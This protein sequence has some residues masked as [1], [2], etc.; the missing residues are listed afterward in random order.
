M[1]ILGVIIMGF[2]VGLIARALMPGP[3]P[4]GIIL[5][6]LLGIGGAFVGHY[7]GLIFGFYTP[8]QPAGFIMSI[9]GAIVLL[10]L[11]GLFRR[12]QVQR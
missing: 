4:A 1:H 5:T 6:I 8:D 9:V 11:F 10:I 3:N 7:L 2:I 12:N